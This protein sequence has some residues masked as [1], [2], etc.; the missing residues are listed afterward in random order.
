VSALIP[1]VF[2]GFIALMAVVLVV[3]YLQAK[4]RREGFAGYAASKGWTFAEQD[5]TL[6]D[7]FEGA[8]FGTGED[9]EASNVMRGT[10]HD[11]PMVVFDY[12]YV[13]TSTSTDAEGHTTTDRD[14]HAFSV[15]AVNTGAVLPALSVT[16]EGMVGRFFGRLTNSDI[17]LESEDFNRAFTV[18]CPNRRFASDVLHPRMMELLLQWPELAWRF[19]ADSLLAIRPGKHDVTEVEAKLAALDAILDTVPD[20]VWREVGG[21]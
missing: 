13:T 7:R 12:A 8:P 21:Q 11:R 10:S 18:T 20:F 9:R 4:R 2:V 1:L 15:M 19:D 6:L 16:P 17:E 14:T 3:G 5:Q